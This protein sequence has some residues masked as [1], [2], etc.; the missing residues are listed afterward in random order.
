MDCFLVYLI[1]WLPHYFTHLIMPTSSPAYC[2]RQFGG[3]IGFLHWQ[4]V[5][6]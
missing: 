1:L 6:R 2:Q 4:W 3:L 5:C